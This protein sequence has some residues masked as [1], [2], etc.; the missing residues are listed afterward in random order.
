[1]LGY[2][3]HDGRDA[4]NER[5]AEIAM[6]LMADGLRLAGAVQTDGQGTGDDRCIA[7]TIL[8]GGAPVVISQSLGA[9]SRGCRLDSGA[10]EQAVARVAA[11]L[12]RTTD[13]L[14]VNKF[15]KQEAAGR[16]FRD[17][18]GMAI[19]EAVPVLTSV[20]V[21]CL[22]ALRDFAGDCAV[23]VDWD[24]AADWCRGARAA[25]A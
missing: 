12:T 8:G 24:T 13:L 9:G 2:I 5:M 17:L 10:L 21:D 18:I 7:L 16:G 15:G 14:I 23:Q 20:S 6:T 22:D 25:A 1:M 4:H 19:S 3:I 11:R